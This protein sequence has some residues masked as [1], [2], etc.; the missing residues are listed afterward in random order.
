MQK[1]HL[2]LV[3]GH[4]ALLV[5]G[6]LG[7]VLEGSTSSYARYPCWEPGLNGSIVFEFKTDQSDGLLMY[8]D[9]GGQFDFFEIKLLS[10][11]LRLRL[12][13]G[14]GA[15][16]VQVGSDLNDYMWHKAELKRDAQKTHLIV[17]DKLENTVTFH[18]RDLMF[19]NV[20]TNSDVFFGGIPKYYHQ[21]LST[22]ALPSVVFEPHYKGHI[23]NIVY[24]TESN[25]DRPGMI[26]SVG[27]RYNQ[28]DKCEVEN[29]CQHGGLCI[30]TDTGATCSCSFVDYTGDFCETG[31]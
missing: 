15:A 22:L 17:D 16:T 6:G 3:I 14:S 13:L 27:L 4:L 9:D 12:N 25:V 7:F 28:V 1:E 24:M 21:R 30:S 23:R 11:S 10:G 31:M 29:P 2:A 19:G 18:S 8:N 20:S 5:W 26:D